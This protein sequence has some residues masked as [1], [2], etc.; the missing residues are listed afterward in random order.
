[1]TKELHKVIGVEQIF[2]A[3]FHPLSNRILELQARTTK[4]SLVAKYFLG[5]TFKVFKNNS[6]KW[7]KLWRGFS[8]TYLVRC[9]IL[10]L[11][12]LLS[13]NL[14]DKLSLGISSPPGK[15]FT[16]MTPPNFSKPK[17]FLVV[18]ISVDPTWMVKYVC[19]FF[20]KCKNML[21]FIYQVRRKII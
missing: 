16:N 15:S 4:H 8:I 6:S 12:I 10:Q 20:F 9:H 17:D 14:Y 2:I 1:M 19:N 11:Q 7:H 5:K 3:A 21:K 18:S 13:D